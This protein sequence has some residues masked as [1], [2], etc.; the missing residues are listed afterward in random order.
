MSEPVIHLIEG[1]VGAGKSTFA[2]RLALSLGAVHLDLDQWMVALF[3]PDRPQDGFLAWYMERKQRCLDQLWRTAQQILDSGKPVVLEL[4]LVGGA[5][6]ARFYADADLVDASL[7]VYVLDVP[8]DER[9]ARVQARNKSTDG[10]FKMV[11]SDEIFERANA[12]WEAPGDT[13]A[14]ERNIQFITT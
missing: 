3:S 10:T 12:A 5:D 8:V 11:V 2:G 7:Q 4:G 9:R 14:A 13:E 1:P 6:R